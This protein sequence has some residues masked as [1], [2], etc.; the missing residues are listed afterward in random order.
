MLGRVLAF[1][2]PLG[3]LLGGIWNHFLLFTVV[4]LQLFLSFR[5]GSLELFQKAIVV[6]A[7]CTSHTRALHFSHALEAFFFSAKRLGD[8]M[9]N[10]LE[11]ANLLFLKMGYMSYQHVCLRGYATSRCIQPRW[12]FGSELLQNALSRGSTCMTN[13]QR[14]YDASDVSIGSS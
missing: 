11:C 13:H 12:D 6:V 14:L 7:L 5:V 9:G 3:P 8:V 1:G 10:D 4:F 2:W